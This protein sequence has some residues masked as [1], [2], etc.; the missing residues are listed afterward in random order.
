MD[1]P[2][3]EAFLKV[4]T[5]GGVSRAALSLGKSQSTVSMRIAGLESFIGAPLFQRE[6]SRMVLTTSG[7]SLLPVA[8]RIM[9]LREQGMRQARAAQADNRTELSVGANTW[10]SSQIM[11]RIAEAFTTIDP[12]TNLQIQV[13]ST[14]AL[15][16]CYLRERSK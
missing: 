13:H 10:T 4:V 7:K 5:E 11:V 2:Q 15:Q 12:G 1:I 8:E 9:Q 6:G 14:P 16:A 3:L